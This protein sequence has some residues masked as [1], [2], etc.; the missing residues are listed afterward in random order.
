MKEYLEEKISIRT[1]DTDFNNRLK[2]N[3]IFVFL[4]D[5]AAAHA[6][7][8][9][10]GY[11][12]LLKNDL[13]WV[14]S[15]VRVEIDKYPKYTDTIKI[16]TWPKCKYKLYS[17]RD[18]LLYDEQGN[19][20]IKA[21]TAWLPVNIK[22]KRI[23]DLQSMNIKI[24]YEPN[25]DAL[26]VYPEKLNPLKESQ[27]IESKVFKYTDLDLNQHVNNTKYVEMI[28]DCFSKEFHSNHVIKNI[29]VSFQSES[30][31]GDE[32][33][34]SISNNPTTELMNIVEAKNKVSG[35]TVFQSVV[36][37]NKSN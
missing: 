16:K 24:P 27:I 5:N 36:E 31:Y 21:S 10:L 8:L 25:E 11:K 18:F 26:N 19:I 1:N 6:D 3:S 20:I 35:K 33:E 28:L 17:M 32:I 34:V 29:T 12:D 22:T 13:G 14:L 15:W 9:H 30:F 4:Q 7:K 37:W 23:V 2:L